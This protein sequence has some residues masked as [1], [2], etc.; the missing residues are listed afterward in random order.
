MEHL[1]QGATLLNGPQRRVVAGLAR[2][3]QVDVGLLE[4]IVAATRADA[5]AAHRSRLDVSAHRRR[6]HQVLEPAQLLGQAL[7]DLAQGDWG[8][9]AAESTVARR[10]VRLWGRGARDSH[11]ALVLVRPGNDIGE[12]RVE[13]L[14]GGV[15]RCV[16]AVD[17]DAGASET[18]KRSL[19][20]VLCRQG[21]VAGKDKG[22]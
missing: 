7:E 16:R 10:R 18:K 11:G 15:H 13:A 17:G 1:H 8:A 4:D 6:N 19:L 2:D 14:G 3:Q 9:E 12:P 21:L 20:R 22:I 5:E